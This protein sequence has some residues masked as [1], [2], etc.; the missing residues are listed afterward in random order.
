MTLTPAVPIFSTV[1]W[2]HVTPAGMISVSPARRALSAFFRPAVSSP[3]L[4]AEYEVAFNWTGTAAEAS[5][6]IPT[7][8][9]ATA[10]PTVNAPVS[11]LLELGITRSGAR[12]VPS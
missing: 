6:G 5:P 11:S 2:R 8:A 1:E 4:Q 3:P 10:S 12:P 9:T 7:P